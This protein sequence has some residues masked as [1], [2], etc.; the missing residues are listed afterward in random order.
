MPMKSIGEL[1]YKFKGDGDKSRKTERGELLR[2]FTRHLN[3]AR[4]ADGY[5]PISMSRMGFILEQIPTG[6]LYHL[7]KICSRAQNFSKKFWWAIDPKKH[8]EENP[9]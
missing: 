9:F 1:G 3:H 7:Q 4:K 8:V 2:F 6:D 5:P